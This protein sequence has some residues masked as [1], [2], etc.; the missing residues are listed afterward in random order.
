MRGLVV[1]TWVPDWLASIALLR[2]SSAEHV[3][4]FKRVWAD[5]ER[6]D[7]LISQLIL[8]KSFPPK[9]LICNTPSDAKLDACMC[10]GTVAGLVGKLSWD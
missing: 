5:F 6:Y 9:R 7:L 4:V 10:A 1:V 8:I 3:V 2:S